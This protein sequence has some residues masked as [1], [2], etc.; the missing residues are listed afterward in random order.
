MS[1]TVD[2]MVKNNKC[3]AVNI[4]GL[5]KVY[6]LKQ[7]WENANSVEWTAKIYHRPFKKKEAEKTIAKNE[8]IDCFCGR[9][10]KSD[11]STDFA[12]P[13]LYNK[14]SNKSFENIVRDI[15]NIPLY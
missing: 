4:R 8:F 14:E 6:L 10:I 2:S 11:L 9:S 15:R 7:L 3:V 13:K 12:S 1:P 5:D